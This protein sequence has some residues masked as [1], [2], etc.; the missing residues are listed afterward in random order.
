MKLNLKK[1]V[2]KKI[3]QKCWIISIR[4]SNRVNHKVQPTFKMKLYKNLMNKITNY[5]F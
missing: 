1:Q 3:N 2:Y 5:N 4:I